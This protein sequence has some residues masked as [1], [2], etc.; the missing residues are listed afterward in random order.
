[1]KKVEEEKALK[2]IYNK[3]LLKRT[4]EYLK[5]AYPS[6]DQEAYLSIAH[7]FDDLTM[8]QRVHL[9]RDT[10]HQLLPKNY[11]KALSILM[12]LARSTKIKDFDLWPI[13][14]FI[15]T[16]GL[17]D[18][19]I[20]MDALKEVTKI[21]TSEWAVRPFIKRYPDETKA[22]LLQC[23][24]DP[25][26]NVRRWASEGTRPRLPWGEN[27]QD[28]IKNPSL[29]IPILDLLKF[30]DEL[31][32]RKSV[33]N[34]L[35]DISKDHPVVVFQLLTKWQKEA[36]ANDQPK[37]DWIRRHAMRTLIKNG[38]PKA[39]ALV[40]VAVNAQ[41]E[42]SKFQIKEKNLSMG[43]KLEFSFYVCSQKLKE[44]NLIIDYRIHFVRALGKSSVKVFK[45]KNVVLKA[46]EKIKIEKKYQFREITTRKY[47]D[48][49]HKLEIQING[50]VLKA[51][52]FQLNVR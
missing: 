40:G 12:N 35:N 15:Q 20:S 5:V 29:N 43:D 24:R 52:P 7:S 41:V 32:V 26:P 16:Y 48:G 49:I 11:P 45:L 36:R 38:H 31:Y 1:M 44:Q 28:F 27:L 37:L 3:N 17:D 39:L 14:E 25:H 21:F 2:N 10:L 34:H 13:T 23:A 30:D 6:F 51:I 47:Y 50:T 33:A 42:V 9:I 18:F 19:V 8:K 22:F 4:G 46:N